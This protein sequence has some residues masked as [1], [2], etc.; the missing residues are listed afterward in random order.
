M[1]ST[2]AVEVR[3]LDDAIDALRGA[4]VEVTDPRTGILEG[5]RIAIASREAGHGVVVQLLERVQQ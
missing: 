1:G 2:V 3:S 5:T 4:G